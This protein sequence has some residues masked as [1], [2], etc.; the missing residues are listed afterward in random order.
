[1]SFDK[2]AAVA[3]AVLFEG[4]ALYPYR[5]SSVKNVERWQ[6]G[7]VAPRAVAE[8]SGCDPWWV[9]AQCLLEGRDAQVKGRLRF[10]R[11]RHHQPECPGVPTAWD[12][13]EPCEIDFS[14]SSREDVFPFEVVGGTSDAEGRTLLGAIRLRMERV[15]ASSP[16]L[17]LTVRVENRT[18]VV[19]PAESRADTLRSCFLG[20]HFMLAATGAEFVSLIEPPEWAEGAAG[21]CKNVRVFP[22]LIGERGA[23]DAMLASPIILYDYPEVAPESPQD[24]FDATEIDGDPPPPHAA[25]HGR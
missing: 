2:A 3:D 21:A 7:V 6:F 14:S 11:A 16:L 22:V 18:P 10:L 13:G 19:G 9:E 25:P 4:Y 8:E 20:A 24:L 5:P 15:S 17:R 12:E 23:R 1:M